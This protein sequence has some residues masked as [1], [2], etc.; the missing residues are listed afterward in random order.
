MLEVDYQAGILY[1]PSYCPI[2][3]WM[4]ICDEIFLKNN[5]SN[6]VH[7]RRIRINFHDDWIKYK[8]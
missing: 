6:N 2:C 3:I 1:F 5:S 4:Y 7:I 8:N